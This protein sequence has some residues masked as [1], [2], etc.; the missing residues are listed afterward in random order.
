MGSFRQRV[1][2]IVEFVDWCI[3]RPRRTT[4]ARSGGLELQ[5]ITV[6]TLLV[7]KMLIRCVIITLFNH[8]QQLE[9]DCLVVCRDDDK[10]ALPITLI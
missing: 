8:L 5:C 2:G 9:R 7:K 4:G 10:N 3:A 6:A 1:R